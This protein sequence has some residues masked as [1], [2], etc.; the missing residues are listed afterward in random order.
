MTETLVDKDEL[1]FF[2]GD[3]GP[4]VVASLIGV[5]L[6][7]AEN[8]AAKIDDAMERGDYA[9][10]SREVH[11]LKGVGGTYGAV[12]M[13]EMAYDLDRRFKSRED[14]AAMKP[15]LRRLVGVIRQTGEEMKRIMAG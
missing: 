1:M 7:D 4:E 2:L 11:T 9:A 5:F 13:K 6:T 3:L 14:L 12:R 10:L 8:T 15:D